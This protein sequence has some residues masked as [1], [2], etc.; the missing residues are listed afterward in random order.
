MPKIAILSP[1]W[2]PMIDGLSGHTDCFSRELTRKDYNILIITASKNRASETSKRRVLPVIN[3]WHFSDFSTLKTHI[4]DN[5]I[6]VLFVQY[7]PFAYA[8][9]GGINYFI[10]F[11][12]LYSRFFLKTKVHT[13]FH[14]INWPFELKPKSLLMYFCHKLQASL[15]SMFSNQVFVSN[16]HFIQLIKS[17]V[18]WSIHPIV[19]NSG[20]NLPDCNNPNYFKQSAEVEGKFLLC[21]FGAFHPSKRQSL[22]LES[23]VMLPKEI[24][25]KLKIVFIGQ[26]SEQIKESISPTLYEQ[27]K[28]LILPLGQLSDQDASNALA[29]C[30][31]F[32]CPYID[33][34]NR[35][36]GTLMAAMKLGIPIISCKGINYES[37]F[38]DI[39]NLFCLNQDADL[40]KRDFHELMTKL[41]NN[42]VPIEKERMMKIY[43]SEFSWEKITEKYLSSWHK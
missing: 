32:V 10:P 43:E 37:I 39:P 3:K 30:N 4:I 1:N 15:L 34:A 36:R 23:I 12:I 19:L 11:F 9:R 2:E 38:S 25:L 13:L 5:K 40:F 20:S 28:N 14:E 27:T 18:P 17:L 24:L 31:V 29:A 6:D 22:A 26:T 7:T 41:F 21:L 42:E 16:I 8:K 35:R 33:G